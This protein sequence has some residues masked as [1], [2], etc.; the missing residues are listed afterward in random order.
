M[1][2][3]PVTVTSGGEPM[4]QNIVMVPNYLSDTM[5]TKR[6]SGHNW[7]EGETKQYEEIPGM[8]VVIFCFVSSLLFIILNLFESKDAPKHENYYIIESSKNKLSV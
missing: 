3:Q 6:D 8:L 5:S 2:S 1:Y 7:N 4:E